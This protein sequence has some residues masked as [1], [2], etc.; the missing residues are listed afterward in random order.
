MIRQYA[1]SKDLHKT[2]RA[3]W[4][5]SLKSIGY[6][7]CKASVAAYYRRRSDGNGFLRFWAQASQWGDNWSGNAFT[8]NVDMKMDDP[9]APLGGSDRLLRHLSAAH[10]ERAEHIAKQIIERKPKPP[11]EHWIYQEMASGGT[12]QQSCREAFTRAFTYKH[13]AFK[14]GLDIWLEYFSV[15]DVA[16]WAEF[17]RPILPSLLADCETRTLRIGMKPNPT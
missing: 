2:L 3:H 12:S 11:K 5:A 15:D 6:F 10:C 7:R 8:L 1:K 17:L 4:D 9:N 14:E 16:L 13:G